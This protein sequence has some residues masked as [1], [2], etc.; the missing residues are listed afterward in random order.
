MKLN[1]DLKYALIQTAY[2]QAVSIGIMDCLPQS[3]NIVDISYVATDI[4]VL[5][6]LEYVSFTI[7]DRVT[8]AGCVIRLT[9][10][11]KKVYTH[12]PRIE[13]ARLAADNRATFIGITRHSLLMY[14]FKDL[15]VE[16]LS[17]FLTHN[18]PEV[19]EIAKT[20]FDFLNTNF[21]RP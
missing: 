17:P 3:F 20:H 9:D 21:N 2:K 15:N 6:K 14:Y 12:I 1:T 13:R 19:R 8:Y 5:E 4:G 18:D 11:G 10:M 7:W 16:E